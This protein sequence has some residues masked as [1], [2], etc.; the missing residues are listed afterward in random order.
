M[1]HIACDVPRLI[2]KMRGATCQG[3]AATEP[4]HVVSNGHDLERYH[5]G[6]LANEDELTYLEKHLLA[7]SECVERAEQTAEYVDTVRA[8]VI[9]G[10]FD[11][12]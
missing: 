4:N 11:L 2:A 7:C 9:A 6:M 8:R 3:I 1:R 10:N 12:D 5:L